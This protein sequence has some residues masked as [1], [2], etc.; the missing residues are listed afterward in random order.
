VCDVPQRGH[1][2]RKKRK[3]GGGSVPS[4]QLHACL[5]DAAGGG[6]NSTHAAD[7]PGKKGQKEGGKK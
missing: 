3:S 1:K 7:G 2:K 6:E 4:S 5:R